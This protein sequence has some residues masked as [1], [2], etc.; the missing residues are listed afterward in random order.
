MN[1]L[2]LP[3]VLAAATL[4][5]SCS[6]PSS[7]N[8]PS[9][10]PTGD[11]AQ[12]ARPALWETGDADT[13]IILLGSVHILPPSLEWR[14]DTLEQALEDA[15]AVY[16]E[17]DVRPDPQIIAEVVERLGLYVPPGNLASRLDAEQL[18]LLRDACQSLGV[19]FSA[20][21]RMRPWLAAMTL[22]EQMTARAG[23]AGDSGVERV[24]QPVLRDLGKDIRKLETVE[25]QLR[26]FSDLPEETQIRY[27][28]NGLATIDE[29][30]A[31]LGD[32]VG[33]W[34]GGD[35]ATLERIM[36][37]EDLAETPE[38]YERLLVARNRNWTAQISALIEQEKGVFLVIVG[39]GHLAG[40]DSLIAMLADEGR[41]IARIQ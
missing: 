21:N 17:T 10:Q 9:G 18:A 41:P 36:I 38:I 25:E 34:A 30:I 33:A 29:D 39:A 23:Y 14:S 3:A 22:S 37:D 4:L 28:M 7:A 2:A 31:L 6:P 1:R 5:L 27:L 13:R 24:L 20:I 35:M 11:A 15:D 26:F 40:D 19:P 32:L 8:E 16:F 12:I